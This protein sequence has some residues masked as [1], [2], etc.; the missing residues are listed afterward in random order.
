MF[1][2]IVNFAMIDLIQTIRGSRMKKGFTLI[3]LLIVVL[4]IGVLSSIALPQYQK[5]VTRAKNREALL[6]IRAIGQGIEMYNLANGAL[7][8]EKEED[9]SILG[10]EN[11]SSENWHYQFFCVAQKKCFIF[12]YS[13]GDEAVEGEM[14]YEIEGRTNEQ[15]HLSPVF[16]VSEIETLEVKDLGDGKSFVRVESRDAGEK[17]CKKAGGRMDAQEG[18]IIE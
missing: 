4:S 6:G 2:N 11:P 17:M 7:P 13:G 12:A 10:I 8:D 16:Y 9:L 15:G 5:A 14:D 3:E 18:C 1:A